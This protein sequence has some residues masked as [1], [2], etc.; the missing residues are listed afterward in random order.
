M[1]QAG[2]PEVQAKVDAAVADILAQDIPRAEAWRKYQNAPHALELEELNSLALSGLAHAAARWQEYC[3]GAGHDPH[4]TEYFTAYALARM[5][6]AMLDAMR[7][8]DWVTR[9]DRTRAKAL[10]D[11]GQ[12][13]GLSE[14]ELAKATGMSEAEVRRTIAVVARKPVSIDAEPHDVADPG[15][16]EGQAVVSSVL[17][18]VT[19]A[20]KRLPSAAQVILAARYYFGMPLPEAAR[21]AGISED[22]GTRLHNEAVLSVHDEMIRAVS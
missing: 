7:S 13:R 5:R 4:R 8:N 9:S 16:V 12:D 20:M 14:A 3:K 18:A 21:A 2:D 11:A 6:G 17:A 19:A 1:A 10:R 22:E 15:D